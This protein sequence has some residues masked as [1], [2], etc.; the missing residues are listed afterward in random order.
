[1]QNKTITPI[2]EIGL[3]EDQF[4]TCR[5]VNS[6]DINDAMVSGMLTVLVD[7]MVSKYPEEHREELENH[8]YDNFM[9][10]RESKGNYITTH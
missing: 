4:I 6:C 3:T 5:L 1:M 10:M 7:C 9:K 8:I 2:I